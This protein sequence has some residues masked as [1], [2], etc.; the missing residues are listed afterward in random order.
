MAFA[1]EYIHVHLS[2]NPTIR[3][4]VPHKLGKMLTET[5]I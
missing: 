2:T 3:L 4:D 1:Y 5:N